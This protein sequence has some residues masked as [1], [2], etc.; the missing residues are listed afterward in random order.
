MRVDPKPAEDALALDTW[1]RITFHH[2]LY[3]QVIGDW[4]TAEP[5]I[6][7]QQVGAAQPLVRNATV[8]SEPMPSSG[9]ACYV[10]YR[11]ET[12]M[13]V[14]EAHHVQPGDRV[15]VTMPE[16]LTLTMH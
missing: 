7:G 16:R 15:E 10:M 8:A 11:D 9:W 13:W 1:N 4:Q 2:R 14:S 6:I 3:E 5:E 12:P